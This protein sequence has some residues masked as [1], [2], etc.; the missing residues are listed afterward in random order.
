[1][2]LFFG[3]VSKKYDVEQIAKGYYEA[4]KGSSWFGEIK[5]GDHCYL[6]GGEKIQFWR[7]REWK[8]V[9]G[10]DRLCFDIVNA[11]LGI[12]VNKLSALK[13][14]KLSKALIVLT[15]RSARNKA[16]FKLDVIGNV[17]FD[18]LADPNFYRDDTL[19]RKI[20]IVD[21][22]AIEDRSADIQLFL[23]DGKLQ[24]VQA[25]FFNA[26]VV[27]A[28]R[29]NLRFRGQGAKRKDRVLNTI[30]NSLSEHQV[31]SVTD[32]GIR[33]FYDSFF[34]EYKEREKYFLLGAFWDTHDP[35]DQTSTFVN[36]NRWQNGYEDKFITDTKAIPQGSHVA[37]KSAYVKEKSRAAMMIK[38]RGTV[39][40]N[41]GDGRNI[42]VKWEKNFEPFEVEFGGYMTTVKEV[43]NKDHIAEIWENETDKTGFSMNDTLFDL[44]YY[45]KQII[46]QGPPGTGKTRLAKKIAKQMISLSVE[47]IKTQLAKGLLISTVKGLK[48]YE[49]LQIEDSQ[50]VLKR[51]NGTRK[52]IPFTEIITAFDEELWLSDIDNNGD[53]MAA[54]VAK[55]LY[56]RFLN[57]NEQLSIVQFHPSY[58]YEDFVRG[59]V[60]HAGENGSISYESENKTLANL[61]KDA[62]ENYRS[63]EK[64][65]RNLDPTSDEI[66]FDQY[67]QHIED[68][69]K[70]S[71]EARFDIDSSLFLFLSSYERIR[72]KHTSW[73]EDAVGFDLDLKD[74]KNIII[75]APED[76]EDMWKNAGV[77]GLS[78]NH[79]AYYFP[80]YQNYLDFKRSVVEKHH[81]GQS[82][83]VE[84]KNYVLIVDEINRANLSSVLGE[85]IYAL[86]YRC[87]SV[88]SMYS[89]NGSN[90][91]TLP[92]NLYII[93][94]MNTADRSVGHID[95]A[96]RRRFA[97]VDVLPEKLT[98]NDYIWFNTLG[99]EKVEKLFNRIN[100]SSEFDVKD[101]QLGHSYFIV[102]RSDAPDVSKRDELFELK[103]KY[104][105]QPILR[106]YVKDGILIGKIDAEDVS[107]YID[108]L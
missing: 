66:V 92:P 61:A 67:I 79:S 58:T 1:M 81:V 101:V 6:I 5:E 22:Q 70:G 26:D 40:Q 11:D 103:M 106:E 39:I 30:Y 53:R 45:K 68:S 73:K 4:P 94:T 96:I 90:K 55:F 9:G 95:Y 63:Y 98:D 84:L 80:I 10:K 33:A 54:A 93:G 105:I 23:A 102:K 99:Y 18:Q 19:Y 49:V 34:C 57:D 37:I 36:E 3:K 8:I 100:V 77:N 17:E 15:S 56:D 16:F 69:I 78:V 47:S 83:E 75:Y 21:K 44:V 38:A 108:S 28:Y 20:K 82:Y 7:A 27:K 13:F 76:E 51:E 87:E 24:L 2:R 46:L 48:K 64:S 32:L 35:Q 97:F 107:A 74:L 31:F 14:L 43:V 85:L 89:V 42:V 25:S 29:D 104:E 71:P 50:L 62:L 88:T 91:L 86:E 60:V 12:N 72:Y 59:I 41:I 65:L 52:N